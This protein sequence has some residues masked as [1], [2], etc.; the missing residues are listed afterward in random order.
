M[1]DRDLLAVVAACL[2]AGLI[3]MGLSGRRPTA[4]TTT[5]AVADEDEVAA[6]LKLINARR[7][8]C[9][10]G[11]GAI[12][13]WKSGKP[14][15]SLHEWG[16]GAP[17]DFDAIDVKSPITATVDTL[18]FGGNVRTTATCTLPP[19]SHMCAVNF[20]F[21]DSSGPS[22]ARFTTDGSRRSIRAGC[23][24]HNGSGQE[25]GVYSAQ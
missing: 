5:V 24:L 16:K 22:Y 15:V 19:G 18:D 9:T 13:E 20:D 10:V 8:H 23:T 7:L 12:A 25:A 3:G 11:P 21:V 17:M 2:L 1:R 14:V 4:R 6:A